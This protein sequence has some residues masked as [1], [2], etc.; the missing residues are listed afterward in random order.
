[1]TF[2]PETAIPTFDGSRASWLSLA[3]RLLLGARPFASPT[4][5]LFN[6]P[7]PS[8]ASG[9]WSDGMEGFARTFLLA[10]FRI[11]GSGGDDPA[12]LLSRYREGLLA[13]V[14]PEGAERWPTIAERRQSV[15]EAAS[16]AIALSET[17]TWL[18][19]LLTDDDR[20]RIVTW[21]AG[22]VG[23][24][25][26]TNN[27]IWF[28]NII[29]AFL[30][31]VG[32]PWSADDLDRNL[33]IQEGLYVG[34]GWYSDGAG[35]TGDRQSFDYYAGWAW[36]VYPLLQSR[37]RGVPMAEVHRERLA[38]FLGQAR[39]LVGAHGAPLFQG[40]SLTY[41]FGMLAPFWSAAIAGV[42]PLASGE[43]RAL[44]R[45]VTSYFL[46]AGAVDDRRLLSI[47]WHGEFLPIRQVYTSGS[48]TYWAAKGFL[49]LLL[50]ADHPE[51]S[52]PEPE[53]RPE[54]PS[55]R[56]LESP[57]WL[58]IDTPE[59]GVV[60]VLNHGSDGFRGASG[61]PRA[62]NPF[63]QRLS[64]SNTTAPEL[65][66]SA[67]AEPLECHIALVDEQ[68]L[69]SHRDAIERV[70]LTERVAISRSRVHW[71]DTARADTASW[72]SLRRGPRM[73]TASVVHGAREVRLAWWT[74]RVDVARPSAAA[75]GDEVWPD[76]PG[77][78]RFRLGGWALPV[79]DSA[80]AVDGVGGSATRS[81]GLTS[82]VVPLR[83]LDQ[84]ATHV[85]EASN[86]FERRSVTPWASNSD[87]A[88]VGEVIAALVV[89]G[90]PTVANVDAGTVAVTVADGVARVRWWDGRV[91]LV[92]EP[93]VM[94]R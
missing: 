84:V 47:G 24:S 13:G 88:S 20:Q 8:S 35:A 70:R 40:R 38:A 92:A 1:M 73:T 44:A 19:E 82:V 58:V 87:P 53:T 65:S 51:W 14:D 17:R 63:Y 60:R 49:G 3:D 62:D 93:G 39:S 55:V 29:E 61:A 21:L 72:A 94:L 28:Q 41:R 36:H 46:D 67:I 30:A 2:V 37:I 15:V 5:A 78:W 59:D 69:P 80:D 85:R 25:G 9:A 83:G 32:G 74:P 31:Q 76:D 23:T 52:T 77:P 66:P 6:F 48:S 16:I 33:E 64:Y 11:A 75:A 89:L 71:L 34:D 12:D 26:Y 56:V 43:T 54:R 57:G 79:D 27:W 86:A 68:G 45:R 90:D 42:S 91:D 22:I 18:W 7:G 50:P 4:G 10:A 81:D